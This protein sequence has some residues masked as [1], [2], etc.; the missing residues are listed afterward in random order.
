[1]GDDSVD[2]FFDVND[3]VVGVFFFVCLLLVRVDEIGV[4]RVIYIWLLG[5]EYFLLG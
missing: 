2:K 4:G 5:E 1:M 3:G